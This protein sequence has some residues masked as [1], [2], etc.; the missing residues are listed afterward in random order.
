[1]P[2]LGPKVPAVLTYELIRS[3]SHC[4]NYISQISKHHVFCFTLGYHLWYLLHCGVKGGRG[5]QSEGI[6]FHNQTYWTACIYAYTYSPFPAI[7]MGAQSLLLFCPV[8]THVLRLGH[9]MQSTL[10]IFSVERLRPTSQELHP[11]NLPLSLCPNPFSLFIASELFIIWTNYL[12]FHLEE[13]LLWPF[14]PL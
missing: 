2:N 1:M 7:A 14:T 9:G 11:C 12:V 8:C 5:E 13:A 3:L 10:S 4:P 6:S